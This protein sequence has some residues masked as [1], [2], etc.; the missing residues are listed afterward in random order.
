M[1]KITETNPEVQEELT[2]QIEKILKNATS[3]FYNRFQRL[4]KLMLTHF[5]LFFQN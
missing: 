4:S 1:A 3:K 5:I 2:R